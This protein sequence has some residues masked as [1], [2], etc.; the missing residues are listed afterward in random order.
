MAVS[1]KQDEVMNFKHAIS[2]IRP[3]RS[4]IEEK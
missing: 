4:E 2:L 3:D 1:V